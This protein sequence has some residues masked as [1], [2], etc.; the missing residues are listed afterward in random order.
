MEKGKIENHSK[1]T[2]K[3]KG[4]NRG[5]GRTGKSWDLRVAAMERDLPENPL[6]TKAYLEGR[7]GR[8]PL[9]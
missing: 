1:L 9:R 2:K 5:R 4:L 8:T 6:R 3:R 7:K